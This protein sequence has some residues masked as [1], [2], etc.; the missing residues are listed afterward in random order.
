MPK[1]KLEQELS[2]ADYIYVLSAD[3]DP[4]MPTRRRGH[5]KRLLNRGKARIVSHVPFVIQL[6]Y[7]GPKNTQPPFGGIDPGRTN[8]GAAVVTPEGKCVYRSHTASRNRDVPKKMKARKSHRQASRRGERLR[9]KRRARANRTTTEFPNGRMLP[10]YKKPVMVKDIVNTTAKFNYRKRHEKW[11]TPTTNQLVQTHENLIRRITA[12]LPV[13]DWTIEANKF[14]FMQMDNGKCYGIDFQNG[15]MKS[16]RNSHEYVYERQNG[17]CPLCGAPIEHYHHIIPRSQGGSDLPENILGGCMKCHERIHKGELITGMKGVMKKYGALSV[18]N[19]AIPYIWQWMTETYGEDHAHFCTGVETQTLRDDSGFPKDHDIDAFC[20]A[21]IGSGITP[22]RRLSH[23]FEIVQFR[24]HDRS[25]IKSQR[26]RT[27]RLDGRTVCRNR[28]KRFEQKEDSL[29]EFRQKYPDQVS[30]LTVT[31]SMHY[32][33][34]A[35]RLMPGAVF[36]FEGE[37]YVLQ[38]QITRG[39]YYNA[40]ECEKRNFPAAKCTIIRENAGLVYV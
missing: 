1:T 36:L 18:L 31:K 21:C 20:I 23:T 11:L 37:R 7:D 5:V 22:V 8:I 30:R 38:G 26:E 4:L 14:A 15:R 3:G 2:E 29:E 34:D 39:R 28:H 19:Q 13:T 32:Y 12:I 35:N 24:R 16:Y 6:K 25:L 9:R 27:Y 40:I 10:G 17:V 33:N